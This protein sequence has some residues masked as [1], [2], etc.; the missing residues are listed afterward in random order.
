MNNIAK[1]WND[2]I[3][4]EI[5]DNINSGIKKQAIVQATGTGKSYIISKVIEEL[6]KRNK[7]FKVLYLSP[8][9]EINDQ[10]ENRAYE[11]WDIE[12]YTYQML[13]SLYNQDLLKNN[14]DMIIGDELHRILSVEWYKAYQKLIE[15][16]P[17]ALVF[18]MTATPRRV[19]QLKDVDDSVDILFDGMS[20]SNLTLP[21]AINYGIILPPEY[22]VGVYK[23]KKQIKEAIKK[24]EDNKDKFIDDQSLLKTLRELKAKWDGTVGEL[25]VFKEV[26]KNREKED[27]KF[28]CFC[29]NKEFI[30]K[31]ADRIT[32]KISEALDRHIKKYVYYSGDL[33][34]IDEWQEFKNAK[35]G[36]NLLFVVN[37]LNEGYHLQDIDGCIMYR[38]TDSHIIYY[39]QLGRVIS[40]GNDRKPIV[41][42][43]VNNQAQF[44][45]IRV[46]NKEIK[47]SNERNRWNYESSGRSVSE[48]E[49][50]VIKS[51]I[52]ELVDNFD[53]NINSLIK[54]HVT[55]DGTIVDV[56]ELSMEYGIEEKH[57]RAW[58]QDSK[59]L[60]EVKELCSLY[61]MLK[62]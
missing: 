50:K 35:K 44:S 24:Y 43:M 42:D 17:K 4:K 59:T 25:E 10:F 47:E 23:V 40:V 45:R 52:T 58:I 56:K 2:G 49:F 37:I 60:D 41:I 32:D 19:D 61:A 51:E 11:H 55:K 8:S 53:K 33:S 6:T 36:F 9:G 14:Y 13:L 1:D 27:Y 38:G 31:N 62:D 16:N 28:I 39:Q 29:P 46:L 18:G 30:H 20:V 22:Y 15:L 34:L 5:F 21:E 26:F 54:K 12:I 48:I 7:K 57:I 3:V